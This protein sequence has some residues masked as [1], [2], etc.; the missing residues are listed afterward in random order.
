M[1]AM[2]ATI[3]TGWGVTIICGRIGVDGEGGAPRCGCGRSAETAT[4]KNDRVDAATIAELPALQLSARMLHGPDY[5]PTGSGPAAAMRNLLVRQATQLKN[6]T[7]GLLMETGVT[8][9][10]KKLHQG[11]YFTEFLA[12]N[13]EISESLQPLLRLN[14]GCCWS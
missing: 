4:K 14:Q 3:F 1:A 11:G 7:A 5:D 6:K 13:E 12:T 10:K 2:E 8:Y 9:N